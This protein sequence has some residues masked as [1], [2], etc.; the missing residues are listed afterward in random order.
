MT[1]RALPAAD[2]F[3]DK[4]F[5][6]KQVNLVEAL[7]KRFLFCFVS[8]KETRKVE[9]YLIDFVFLSLSMY[10]EFFSMTYLPQGKPRVF[11]IQDI[12]VKN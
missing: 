5:Q 4:T 7:Q 2:L 6:A 10:R 1:L 9:Y 3:S 8:Y 12:W 11:E